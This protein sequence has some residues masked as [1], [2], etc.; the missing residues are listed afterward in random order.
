MV[1]IFPGLPSIMVKT[2]FNGRGCLRLSPGRWVKEC[3]K[4][5]SYFSF[6]E[7]GGV[8]LSLEYRVYYHNYISRGDIHKRWV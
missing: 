5:I 8:G 7:G 6:L 4:K 2:R 3:I 1:V